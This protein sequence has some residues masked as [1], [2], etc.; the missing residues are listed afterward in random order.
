MNGT[1]DKKGNEGSGTKE[2]QCKKPEESKCRA[3]ICGGGRV[4]DVRS[5]ELPELVGVDTAVLDCLIG[6]FRVTV[7]QIASSSVMFGGK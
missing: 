7:E 5:E 6:Y 4:A 2:K 1:G 3:I